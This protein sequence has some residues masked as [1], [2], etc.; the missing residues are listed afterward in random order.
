MTEIEQ[1]LLDLYKKAW[2]A[3]KERNLDFFKEYVHDDCIVVAPFGIFNKEKA[4]KDI[5]KNPNEIGSY[6][7]TDPVV[8]IMNEATAIITQE[9]SVDFI[10]EQGNITRV[11]YVTIAFS[12]ENGKWSMV[13]YQQTPIMS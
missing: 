12:K 3:N 2:E 9:A 6:Q 4:L 11:M 8:R 5:E 10:T 7:L 1:E 13:L